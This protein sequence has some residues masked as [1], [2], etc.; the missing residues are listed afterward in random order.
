MLGTTESPEM[1]TMEDLVQHPTISIQQELVRRH[2][3]E[4]ETSLA[5]A[6]S[7][8]EAVNIVELM[9]GRLEREC[10]SSL[11]VHAALGYMMEV[12]NSSWKERIHGTGP[13]NH[14]N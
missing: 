12:A 5:N 6:R 4:A 14:Y 13:T 3:R 10:E 2:C 9:C 1:K 8:E 7:Y 11:I